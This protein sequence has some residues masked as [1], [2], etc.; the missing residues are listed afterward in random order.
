MSRVLDSAGNEYHVEEVQRYCLL[1]LE[2]FAAKSHSPFGWPMD[3]I[4]DQPYGY[5][6][7]VSIVKDWR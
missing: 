2:L 1:Q 4:S 5:A 6:I 3:R 7:H